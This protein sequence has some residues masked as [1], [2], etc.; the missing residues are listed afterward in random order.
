MFKPPELEARMLCCSGLRAGGACWVNEN[1]AATPISSA[2]SPVR[3]KICG[4]VLEPGAVVLKQLASVT[5]GRGSDVGLGSPHSRDT[6]IAS[7]DPD[8]REILRKETAG[9]DVGAL[10][11]QGMARQFKKDRG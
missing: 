3:T 11:A 7:G 5:S 6:V 1:S 10:R 9:R 8:P 4:S 2:S